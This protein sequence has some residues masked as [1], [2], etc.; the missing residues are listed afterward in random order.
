MDADGTL[1][2]AATDG[3]ALPTGAGPVA[4][5]AM[6][7]LHRWGG[8][9]PHAVWVGSRG[10]GLVALDAGIAAAPEALGLPGP[11]GAARVRAA[12]HLTVAEDRSGNPLLLLG[13][14]AG[15][16]TALAFHGR[17]GRVRLRAVGRW[18]VGGGVTAMTALGPRVYLA[19]QGGIWSLDL[20]AD[21]PAPVLEA[22]AGSACLDGAQGARGIALL[23][24]GDR[25]LLAVAQP[26]ARRIAVHEVASGQD[27]CLGLIRVVATTRARRGGT[28]M[29]MAV[30]SA[31]GGA[32]HVWDSGQAPPVEVAALAQ[33]FAAPGR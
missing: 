7:R 2:V 19:A 33:V 30:R 32:I 26:A 3:A 22:A 28:V 21:A 12:T 16:L 29:P 8:L 27:P 11:G 13:D 25:L 1:A 24:G 15:A 31:N 18:S 17:Y 5:A 9:R 20:A 6:L 23:R 10:I 14:R 4:G